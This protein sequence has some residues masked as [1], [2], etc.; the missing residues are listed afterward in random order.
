MINH[1]LPSLFL[2]L[3]VIYAMKVM[4]QKNPLEKFI[5]NAKAYSE[6]LQISTMELFGSTVFAKTLHHRFAIGF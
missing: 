6:P 1:M 4:K 5:T 3:V 2:E